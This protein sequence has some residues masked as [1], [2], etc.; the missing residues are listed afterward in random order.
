MI[1]TEIQPCSDNVG[2]HFAFNWKAIF[3]GTLFT[4]GLCKNIVRIALPPIK[5]TP[6]KIN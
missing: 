4:R 3:L 5:F 2:L 1:L 6:L